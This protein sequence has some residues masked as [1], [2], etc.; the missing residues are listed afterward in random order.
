MFSPVLL[1]M[2]LQADGPLMLLQPTV[3]ATTVCFVHAGDLWTVPREGGVARRLTSSAGQETEPHYSPDGKW[4]AFSGQYEGNQDVYVVPAEGGVPKRLT[5]HP[6]GESV[7]GWTRDGRQ[8]LFASNE[9][10][11]PF[12]P[13]LYTVPREGGKPTDLPFPSG[14]MASYSPDGKQIALVP[15]FHFQAA[16]KRYR[17]GA[18]NPIWIANLADSS[19]KEIPRKGWNDT[20]PMW[21][22]NKIYYLSD[23]SGRTNLYS[24]DPSGGGQKELA[25]SEAFDFQSATE[26]PGVIAL[27]QFDS[28]KLFDTATGKLS[29]VPVTLH[30]DFPEVRSK[31]VPLADGIAGGDISPNGKR[32][33][34]ESRG[35]IVT[36]PASKGDA[37]NLTQSSAS[38]ERSPT[39]SPD[40]RRIAYFSD[41]GGEYR[42]VVQPSDG[43]G[44]AKS[45]DPGQMPA[46][47]SQLTFSPD[48]NKLAYADNRGMLWLTDIETGKSVKVD[49]SPLLP[50]FYTIQPSFSPDS[51]W[52]AYARQTENY[53]RAVFLYDVE[54]GKSIQLTDGMSD[55]QNPAF[56]RGGK[57][58]YFTASTNTKNT[59]GWLDL[60]FLNTPNVTSSVYVC[61]L[62]DD[63][64]SPFS[65]ESDD[66]PT[67]EPKKPDEKKEKEEF[68]IDLEG[69]GQRVLAVPMPAR[70]YQG[71]LPG[72]PGTF[73]TA[74]T[75]P[76]PS[77]SS[78]SGP[79]VVRKFDFNSRKESVFAAGANGF[80][81]SAT[82]QH[83]LLFAGGGLSIVPTAMPPQP[84]QGAVNLDSTVLRVD[85]RA[86]WKQ[87][88][89]EV[90]RIQRDY[91]YDPNYHG[92]D[93]KALERK[94]EP[95]M[96]RLSS[97]S[98]LNTLFTDMLGE[99]CVGHMYVGGGDIP[100]ISG[101]P[102][103]L[104]G[105]D[106]SLE[107]GRYRFK[108]IFSGENWN[109]NLRAPLTQPGVGVK[110]G[111]Y[112]IALDGRE[113]KD[114]DNIFERL[115]ARAGKQVRIKVSTSPSGTDAREYTVV[116]VGNET[117]LRVMGWIE[118]NRRKVEELSG[119]RVGY[120]WI[121]NTSTAGYDY[122][123]RWFYAQSNRDGIVLDERFNGGGFVDDYFTNVAGRPL[124][125]WWWTRYGRSFTSPAVAIFGPKAMIINQYAGSGG[126]Y[127]P[128]AFKRSKL[129]PVVGKRTWGGL[130]GI[131]GF[132]SLMDGGGV[133]S[134]NL[135]F[136][137]PEGA[138]EIENY[139]TAPD[140]DVEWDPV[141]WRQGRD[142]QL[143]RAVE[144]VMKQLKNYKRP[145]PTRPAWKDNTKIGGG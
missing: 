139:G 3:N 46:Y 112:I 86:E 94:Y 121:P 114:T 17:G 93:L 132:P 8:I 77:S 47:Y 89:H 109:P 92:V 72:T 99:L 10:P 51:K 98:D 21:V 111:D 130:V 12:V 113:L 29:T 57:Y 5:F 14:H 32:I 18:A 82:G 126:D 65:P 11:L 76:V 131:L 143:E 141:L 58:L 27:G 142:S 19:W 20:Y 71:L 45:I 91:F 120:A 31:F 115:E 69:I 13:R 62:R 53:L 40:G 123:N 67:A 7:R 54:K 68:R 127:L 134:P 117:G 23:R 38:M 87:M 125:S 1:A 37:R 83:M 61:V 108:R 133:T 41:A 106:Y 80:A 144:E 35:E 33:V 2:A 24:C 78:P 116:P 88:L 52:I 124:M 95:F 74:D 140:V 102:V 9:G 56:D 137:S 63:L 110:V 135:A 43:A 138:W 118:D 30:G 4:I 34:L 73:F 128:W 105:A 59:A 75:A 81:I 15:Y 16:W 90:I 129:G 79:A 55:A 48:S 44:P 25:K 36:V 26:G 107:N 42:I 49:E 103:G 70:V 101:A 100:G 6:A 136:F 122:F 39:W 66:E 85:P 96:A 64:P 28:I 97:R 145:T 104:L 50:V 119:G 84:G 22:G 60:S